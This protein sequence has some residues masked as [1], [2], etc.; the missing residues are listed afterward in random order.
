MRL[1]LLVS[2]FLCCFAYS[3]AQHSYYIEVRWNGNSNPLHISQD[4]H[5]TNNSSVSVDTITLLDWN[6]AYASERSPLGMFLA[7]DYDY[8]LIR[9][10]KINR[11]HTTITTV[12]TQK[13]ELPWKRMSNAIDVIEISLSKPIAPNTSFS[14]TIHYKLQLPNASIFKYGISKKELYAPY[15]HLVLARQ[16]QDGTWI[17]ESNLGFGHPNASKAN[18]NYR[19][20][21][22]EEINQILPTK[23]NK[24]YSP[25]LLTTKD[26][27]KHV[28]F[29]KSELVT[30]M[31]PSNKNSDFERELSRISSFIGGVFPHD[32]PQALWALQKD[33]AQKPLLALESTPQF[34]GAFEKNQVV[35]L[36]LLKTILEHAVQNRFSAQQFNTSWITGGLPY[37]LWQ[38]YVNQYYPNLK[39][40]GNLNSWPFI[41]KYHFTQA[42]YYRS[43][44]IAANVS[45]NNNRGQA[46]NT[47]KNELTRYNRRVANP[48]RAGLAL[49]YL[50]SYLENGTLLDA[51]KS[52]PNT[53]KLDTSL[54]E[55]LS[56]RT[57]K[58]IDWFFDHYIS[59]NNNID[60]SIS[61]KKTGKEQ[62]ELTVSST[63]ENTAIPLSITT[64]N[65]E[66]NTQWILGNELPYRQVCDKKNIKEF[67]V[68]KSHLIPELSLNNNSYNLNKRLFR[69]NLRLRLFQDI[70]KSGKSVLLLSPDFG[71]NVY[72]GL[73][74]GL[75]A[76]N[77][78]LLSNNF[79]F[80]LS[81]QFG[82]KSGQ[83]NGMGFLVWNKYYENKSLYLTRA[84]IFG[85]SYNYAPNKRYST[86]SPSFQL[87]FRPN[88][89]QQK[90]R[91]SLLIRHISVRLE[92]LPENDSRRNYGVSLASFQTK[93]GDAL[94][95]LSTKTELQWASAFKKLSAE[96]EYIRYYLPNRRLTFRVFAGGFFQNKLDDRYFDYNSSRVNDYLFQYD[97]YGR[98][99]TEGFFS[100]QY[101]KAEG[102]LRTTGAISSANKWLIT[103]QTSTTIWR[104]IEGYAEVGWI[105]NSKQKTH[106]HWGTGVSFNLIPDFFELHFP[107]YDTTGN[108]MT[109]NAY[110]KQIRFQLSLRPATIVRLFSRSW[111]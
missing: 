26:S 97:L 100:Q 101:I 21:I 98:S 88:G 5:W 69:N 56:K 35:E 93:T 71:Y 107:L 85:S 80:K 105:K 106:T 84:T 70:P 79:R 90:D 65:E 52:L 16:N 109:K 18:I 30:D 12:R 75:S 95:N 72:D 19:F 38:Q 31:L 63:K 50:D 111:F 91:S 64:Q 68:N 33:Y 2:C 60:I 58:P 6:H 55:E 42:P 45:G 59:L 83:T 49:L 82:I 37:F 74:T 4:I 44:E 89:I 28:A 10:K 96:T 13:D 11:G 81:P 24:G 104:W 25:I 54:Q 86:F 15:W 99:E 36:K 67:T 39:M 92:D 27:Y 76:G 94:Q 47:P 78:S 23:N 40:T 66:E 7:N 29:G 73:L 108:L 110:V 87:Y 57:D 77:S 53:H 34:I 51:L 61:A 102:A 41:K 20:H 43:W 1:K 22:P 62:Y 9:T 8:K 48:Y 14:F 32:N 46:L 17:K 3:F 103:T